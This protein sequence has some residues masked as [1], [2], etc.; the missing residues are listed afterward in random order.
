MADRKTALDDITS[1]LR[2]GSGR[3]SRAALPPLRWDVPS[4]GQAAGRHMY[5]NM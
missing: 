5:G 1:S 3:L 2:G 4:V